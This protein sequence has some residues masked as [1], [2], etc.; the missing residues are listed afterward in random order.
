MRS[1]HKQST[2]SARFDARISSKV[3][4][5]FK[6]AAQIKGVNE[7]DF[8]INSAM[9]EAEKTIHDHKILELSSKDSE[10]FV[11]ALLNPSLPNN[12]LKSAILD[13]KSVIETQ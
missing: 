8:V 6:E 11:S 10:F 4:N 1:A 9:R 13:Y 12:K 2:R 7:T 5:L 3:K